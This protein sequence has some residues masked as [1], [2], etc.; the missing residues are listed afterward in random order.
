[1]AV[2]DRSSGIDCI[3]AQPRAA[4]DGFRDMTLR[5]ERLVGCGVL[6]ST[7]YVNTGAGSVLFQMFLVTFH[8]PSI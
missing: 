8:V 7:F 1:M 6:G 2:I 3:D 4:R 5:F